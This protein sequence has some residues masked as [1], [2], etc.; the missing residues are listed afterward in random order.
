MADNKQIGIF[1]LMIIFF[2][3]FLFLFWFLFLK[4]KWQQNEVSVIDLQPYRV[5]QQVQPKEDLHE[6]VI[7]QAPKNIIVEEEIVV[8]LEDV[9]RG[10]QGYTTKEGKFTYQPIAYEDHD[11]SNADRP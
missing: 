8:P 10:N 5:T 9:F 3:I 1:Y 11:A 2:L 6:R 7:V 4:D